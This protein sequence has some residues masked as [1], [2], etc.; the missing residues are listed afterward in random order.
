MGSHEVDTLAQFLVDDKIRG[1]SYQEIALKHKLPVDEVIKI[2]RGVYTATT[3]TDP[4]E[5]RALLQLRM[6][7]IIDLMWNGLENGNFKN[8]EVILK[9]IDQLTVLHDLNEKSMTIELKMITDSET[10]KVIE[11]LKTAYNI[12]FEK[13][14]NL[15]LGEDAKKEL[16][17]WPEWVG[18]ATTTA[19]ESVIYAE[20]VEEED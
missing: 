19:V 4:Y 18:E 15:P 3:I 9:A 1:K 16:M 5:Y 20:V 10:L 13:V 17:A 14:N 6:E 11:T 7:K 2:I 8:G 12:I